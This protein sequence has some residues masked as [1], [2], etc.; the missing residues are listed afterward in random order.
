MYSIH[1]IDPQKASRMLRVLEDEEVSLIVALG[2][3]ML[4]TFLTAIVNGIGQQVGE[5]LYHLPNRWAK[6][7]LRMLLQQIYEE[8]QGHHDEMA[9][10]VMEQAEAMAYDIIDGMAEEE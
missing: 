6:L 5:R 3:A 8:D 2:Y 7:R 4:F 10:S 1:Q 9:E